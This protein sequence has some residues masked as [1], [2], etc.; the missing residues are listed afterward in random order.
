MRD[1][2][3]C[4]FS[5][6]NQQVEIVY[7]IR[8]F[9]IRQAVLS[10]AEQFTGPTQSQIILGYLETIIASGHY[11]ESVFSYFT[12]GLGKQKAI[13]FSCTPSDTPPQLMQLRQPESVRSFYNHYRCVRHIHSHLDHDSCDQRINFAF[14]EFGH[15]LLLFCRRH[16]T[17]QKLDGKFRK[18][19]ACKSLPFISGNLN[20]TVSFGVRN[21]RTDKVGLLL[22]L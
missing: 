12:V 16:L 14:S 15:N 1:H 2:L 11:P 8:D 18:N 21:P 22:R 6:H 10:C 13:R 9:Q 4:V 17:V 19:L 20:I 7:D 3:E 5:C